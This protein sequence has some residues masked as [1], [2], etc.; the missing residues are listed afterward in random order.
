MF[1]KSINDFASELVRA[2]LQPLLPETAELHCSLYEVGS[3][4]RI[5][6]TIVAEF[7][8]EHD[9][10]QFGHDAQIATRNQDAG[11]ACSA[12]ATVIDAAITGL[13]VAMDAR[14]HPVR[15]TRLR[16]RYLAG[17]SGIISLN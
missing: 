10:L 11:E 7:G 4:V 6:V 14:Q 2:A 16:N 13:L 15:R 17:G 8:T 1:D 12:I 9:Q 5:S 3:A